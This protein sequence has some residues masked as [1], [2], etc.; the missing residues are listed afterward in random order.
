LTAAQRRDVLEL[1]AELDVP[2]VEDA[3]YE[4]IRFSGAAEP[5]LQTLDMAETDDIERSRVIYCSTFSKTVSPGLRVGWMCGARLHLPHRAGEA[6]RRPAD[7]HAQ[8][9]DRP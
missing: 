5:P 1:C 6:G 2:L 9:D 3:A 7:R 8:P 4:A